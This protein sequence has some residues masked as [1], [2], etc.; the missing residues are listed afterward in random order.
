MRDRTSRRA[1][2]S[3]VP[4]FRCAPSGLRHWRVAITALGLACA[5]SAAAHGQAAPDFYKGKQIQ[6][7]VGYE[8]GNDYDLGARMLARYLPRHIPGQPTIIV[9]N[10][11]QAQSIAAAN[12]LY[13]RAP[14]DGTVMASI[15]RNFASQAAMGQSNIEA[16]PRRLN[17]LGATS[18][19]GRV[20]VA[21]G[22]AIVK[23]P[24]DLFTR[25]LIVGS[26][27]TGSSTSIVP[28]VL[29]RVLGTKFR[30]IEGYRG[31]QD[32]VL[33]IERGEVEGLC[34][35]LGQFRTHERLIRDGKLRI[36]LR[37][38]ET[39][40]PEIPDV[41]S[42]FDFAKSDEQRQLMRFVF[43]STEFG[44]PYIF[45]PDV[46]PER[47]EIMRKAIAEAATDP[48]LVAEAERIKL[49]M[50]YRPPDHL[51][52]LVAQL[53]ETPPATIETVKKI[54]PNFR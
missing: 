35:S 14:R 2:R 46:P 36:I 28:T 19:P 29:N 30:M 7:I 44:R 48:E 22:S 9:Q 37:A 47:V 52:K 23:T 12:S 34:A 13:V 5:A 24:A 16:D 42:I 31:A 40:M 53:Y 17:W 54:V 41:P 3:N 10:Q 45:P 49:D 1:S 25:E 18:F 50:T 26:V 33:A 8:A 38:E 32:V 51:A 15:S 11:P 6:L 27:G 39:V 21:S 20:C 43:S 4:G